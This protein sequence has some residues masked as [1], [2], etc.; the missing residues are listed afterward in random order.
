MSLETLVDE[1]RARG[2]AELKTIEAQR[3]ADL[4]KIGADRD[5]RIAALRAEAAK[6]TEAEV[7]RERAQRVAAAHLAARRLLYEAREERLASGFAE[8][9]KLLANL[10]GEAAYAGIL[11]RMIAAATARLGPSARISG[12]SEDGP[13]LARLGGP[14]FDPTARAILGGVVAETPDGRRRLD[15][16]FDELLRQRADVVR[17]L[18]A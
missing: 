7:A 8:T 3:R 18:L 15:L 16:S 6:A 17:A 5:A 2:E 14:S 11:R 4:D 10:T 13:L 9:R 1:I 12:R